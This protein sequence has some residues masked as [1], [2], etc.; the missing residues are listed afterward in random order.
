MYVR[1]YAYIVDEDACIWI[2]SSEEECMYMVFEYG[3]VYGG[4]VMCI[5]VLLMCVDAY[6]Y[7]Y[8]GMSV[9]I[10]CHIVEVY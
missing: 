7:I 8:D 5:S 9:L 2:Y 1:L 6:I 10:C 3:S 4:I